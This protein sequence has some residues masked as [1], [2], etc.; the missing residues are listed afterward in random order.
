MVMETGYTNEPVHIN[1][2]IKLDGFPKC[3]NCLE[4]YLL[5]FPD[6]TQKGQTLLKLWVCPSCK[7]NIGL[8]TGEII[9]QDLSNKSR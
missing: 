6:E 8:R 1:I 4:G 3:P 9:E 5:P 2:S 7:F